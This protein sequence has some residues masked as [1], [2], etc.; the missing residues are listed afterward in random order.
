[1][2][3]LLTEQDY[4]NAAFD[5][6]VEVAALKAVAEVESNGDGVI[7]IAALVLTIAGG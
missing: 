1:M 3:K 5:L 2:S 4:K 7:I 6:G